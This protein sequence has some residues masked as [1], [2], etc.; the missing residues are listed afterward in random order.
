MM[1][2]IRVLGGCVTDVRTDNNAVTVRIVDLDNLEDADV[3]D[4]A[5]AAIRV[6][7][8]AHDALPY[9]VCENYMP[10]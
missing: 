6:H 5:A 1:I 4:C 10:V 7:N 2:S 8:A 9:E 3:D